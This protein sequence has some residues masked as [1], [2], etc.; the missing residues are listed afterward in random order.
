MST[1][2][3][4]IIKRLQV[5]KVMYSYDRLVVRSLNTQIRAIKRRYA[6]F[7]S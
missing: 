6:V 7:L 5:L 3:K 4:N 1:R 2:D